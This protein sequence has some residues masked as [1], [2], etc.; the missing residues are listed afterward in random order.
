MFSRMSDASKIAFVHLVR[1]LERWQFGMIDCQMNTPLLASFGA[2]EVRRAEFT[3]RMA[4]LVNYPNVPAPWTLE[5]VGDLH[6]T[7][8]ERR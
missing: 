4:E 7:A 2:R 8:A 6:A 5:G 1:H 3:R